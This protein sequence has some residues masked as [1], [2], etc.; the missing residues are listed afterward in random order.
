M[1]TALGIDYVAVLADL[2]KRREDLDKAIA[3][4]EPL[5]GLPVRLCSSE[6]LPPS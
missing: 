6:P 1:E 4:I 3:A 5:A 2:K